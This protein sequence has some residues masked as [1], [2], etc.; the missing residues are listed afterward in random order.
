MNVYKAFNIR[1]CSTV[2]NGKIKLKYTFLNYFFQLKVDYLKL[3]VKL[4]IHI[5]NIYVEMY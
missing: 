1:N 4:M 2:K 5:D 3:L